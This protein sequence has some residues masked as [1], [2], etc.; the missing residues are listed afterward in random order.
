MKKRMPV[1]VALAVLVMGAGLVAA[2][3]TSDAGV[4]NSVEV[5]VG[6]TTWCTTGILCA[7]PIWTLPGGSVDLG[8]AGTKSLVLT[9]TGGGVA[10]FNFDTS[11]GTLPSCS[12]PGGTPCTTII[13]ING[14]VVPF[15]NDLLAANNVDPGNASFNEAANYALYGAN[16]EFQVETGYADNVHTDPCAAASSGDCFPGTTANPFGLG[17]LDTFIGGGTTAPGFPNPPGADHCVPTTATCF[18]AGVLRITQLRTQVPEPSTLLLLGAGI[19][20][21]AAWGSRRS[22]SKI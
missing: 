13:K 19:M 10:N 17:A 1:L 6:N 2:P 7:N 4:V 15:G 22:R 9:Q 14:V 20:G 3:S 11:E 8:P 18:D 5:T 16:A 21:L 12:T